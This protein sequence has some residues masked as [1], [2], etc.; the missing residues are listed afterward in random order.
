MAY[1]QDKNSFT[2]Y[3]YRE[4]EEAGIPAPDLV[5]QV[6]IEGM[7]VRR[8]RTWFDRVLKMEDCEPARRVLSLLNAVVH[9]QASEQGY[10][11]AVD[12]GESRVS[13]AASAIWRDG[14]ELGFSQG[15]SSRKV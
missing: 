1:Q 14:Y 3:H 11:D 2:A 7:D 10:A 15:M 13:N 12:I 4:G 8:L 6:S 9:A 5:E